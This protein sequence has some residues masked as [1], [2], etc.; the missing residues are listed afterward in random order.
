MR[1]Q[2]L[3]RRQ[4]FN[5]CLANSKI[6]YGS[7]ASDLSRHF[8]SAMDFLMAAR[9]ASILP[10]ASG[11]AAGSASEVVGARGSEPQPTIVSSNATDTS[12]AMEYPPLSGCVAS[13]RLIATVQQCN[14]LGLVPIQAQAAVVRGEVNLFGAVAVGYGAWEAT[15]A[16]LLIPRAQPRHRIARGVLSLPC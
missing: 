6:G 8:S 13:A 10:E 15:A 3:A 4:T 11:G 7:S 16:A 12:L 1:K 14:Y 5:F 9:A 2:A